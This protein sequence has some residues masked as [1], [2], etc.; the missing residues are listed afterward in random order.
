MST[1][2]L[3]VRLRCW[4]DESRPLTH[5]RGID[6]HNG[7]ISFPL[8]VPQPVGNLMQPDHPVSLTLPAIAPAGAD[9]HESAVYIDVFHCVQRHANAILLGETTKWSSEDTR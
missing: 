1:I 3:G 4:N 2:Q 5:G 7:H 9:V 6:P 8:L